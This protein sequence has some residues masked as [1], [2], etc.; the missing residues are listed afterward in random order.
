MSRTSIFMFLL[1]VLAAVVVYEATDLR[2]TA[3]GSHDAPS[4]A[5][6]PAVTSITPGALGAGTVARPRTTLP[7]SATTAGSGVS[8]GEAAALRARAAYAESQLE[9]SEGRESTW[10][11]DV[12][13]EYR[14]ESVERQLKKFVVDRGLAKIDRLDCSEFPCVSVLALPENGSQ[15]RQKLHEALNEMIKESYSGRVALSISSSQS[16]TGSDATSI[17]GV[18]VMPDDEDVKTRTR[19]RTNVELQ[20]GGR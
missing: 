2:I 6:Q 10:P 1:G 4:V 20:D 19:H 5:A 11:A 18:S 17:A 15:P 3:H 7:P 14:R 16:G 12:A 9:A 13:P 8:E